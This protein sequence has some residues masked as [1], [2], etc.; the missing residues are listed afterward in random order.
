[1]KSI[2]DPDTSDEEDDSK[3]TKYKKR[4]KTVKST[5]PKPLRVCWIILYLNKNIFLAPCCILHTAG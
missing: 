4:P 3:V 5:S 2:C 1:M